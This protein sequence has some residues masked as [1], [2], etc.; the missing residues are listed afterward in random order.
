MKKCS[1]CGTEFEGNCC[2]NCGTWTE[3]ERKCPKCG[4]KMKAGANFCSYCGFSFGSSSEP[5]KQN[6]SGD[7]K[8]KKSG[9]WFK[10]NL[11]IIIP[12]A[13]VL[14]VVIILACSIPACIKAKDNGTYYKL[15]YNGEIDKKTYFIIDSGE[16]KDE[17]GESG[18][19]KKDGDK[20]IFYYE[21]F[22]SKEELA[23][24]TIKDGVLIIDE[25]GYKQSYI[26]AD[27]KHKYGEWE[28][29]KA[30]CT[31]DGEE[32]HSCACGV[33]EIR[34][35]KERGH[36]VTDDWLSDETNHYKICTDCNQKVEIK[37]HS[38]NG[39]CTICY[40]GTVD[41]N[42]LKFGLNSDKNG[43]SVIGISDKTIKSI[44]IPATCEGLPVT[45][46]DSN[47]FSG[48]K[49]LNSAVIP[50]SVIS[51]GNYA[52]RDCDSLMNITI[53]KGVNYIGK[54]IFYARD[55]NSQA[56]LVIR[57]TGDIASW[58]KIEGVG[59]LMT[60]GTGSK[61]KRTLYINN[62]EVSGNLIIPEG[63]TA[64]NSGAFSCCNGLTSVK[65]PNSVTFIGAG[66]FGGC[67]NLIQTENSVQYVDKWV[68]NCDNSVT[69]ITLRNDTKGI[70]EYAFDYCESLKSVTI[71]NSV[72]SIGSSAFEGCSS[73][74][75][76]TIPDS[77]IYI[78]GL[79]FKDCISLTNIIIPDSI[80]FIGAWTFSD[81][82][83][84][85]SI[86]FKGTKAEWNKISK[87]N[88]WNYNTPNYTIHCTDGDIR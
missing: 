28:I 17:D 7:G 80:T 50:D 44:T 52:F 20:I 32:T 60:D 39:Y 76:I 85:T 37:E 73:L 57:Y 79:A 15:G 83:S 69:Q 12:I 56:P 88:S 46:I 84:L 66:A 11:K 45:Y 34:I 81:C 72:T 24:G 23:N 16:W 25:G 36:T 27:H 4:N 26:S 62:K 77:V 75:S 65:I 87:G 47:V 51:I 67:E 82:Y 68:I 38:N 19:Y 18:T 10:R 61:A 54:S 6:K 35:V 86:T 70:A 33:K 49:N 14:A 48:C 30:P 41:I 53:G 55:W 8:P 9:N 3:E 40:Y 2:P 5:Q 1:N 13:I 31:E 43:Y 63:V 58:C 74:T 22:G 64:I 42:G 71:P 21:F 78:G 59:G 29:T